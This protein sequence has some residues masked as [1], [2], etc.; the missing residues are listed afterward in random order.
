M[1]EFKKFAKESDCMTKAK[2]C[3]NCTCGRAE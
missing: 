3:E 2:P 1:A